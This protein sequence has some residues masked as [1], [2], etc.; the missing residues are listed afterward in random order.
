MEPERA[1][2]NQSEPGRTRANQGESGQNRVHR[3]EDQTENQSDSK[4]NPYPTS[5]EPEMK[6]MRNV[7]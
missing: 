4:P 3:S 6:P 7:K 5:T 1:R 2:G